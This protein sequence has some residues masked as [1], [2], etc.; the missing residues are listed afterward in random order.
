MILLFFISCFISPSQA[1]FNL[2]SWCQVAISSHAKGLPRSKS[3]GHLSDCPRMRF[4]QCSFYSSFCKQAPN[5]HLGLR[6]NWLLCISPHGEVIVKLWEDTLFASLFPNR[7]TWSWHAWN[8]VWTSSSSDLRVSHRHPW[9]VDSLIISLGPRANFDM[10]WSWIVNPFH[11][12]E[13]PEAFWLNHLQHDDSII[14]S[15]YLK[16]LCT[17]GDTLPTQ[18]FWLDQRQ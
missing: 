8:F 2:F 14:C 9:C 11:N 13:I 18:A 12:T 7:L 17:I 16:P 1:G 6:A 10:Q 4:K 3:E 5:R 15:F